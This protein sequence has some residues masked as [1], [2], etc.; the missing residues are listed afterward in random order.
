VKPRVFIASS[1]EGA[2]VAEGVRH[3]LKDYATCTSWFDPF[4][5]T[6]SASTIDNLLQKS[7]EHDF[8]I[9]IFSDDDIAKIRGTGVTVPRDNVVFESGLF[10]GMHGKDRCYIVM[11]KDVTDFH[12]LTDLLGY[13][14]AR[15]DSKLAKT[16]SGHYLGPAS[17]EII[18]A[19]EKSTWNR[20]QLEIKER[21]SLGAAT[22]KY[23]LKLYIQIRNPNHHPVIIESRSFSINPA[24][25][26]SRNAITTKNRFVPEFLIYRDSDSSKDVYRQ[27]CI[28]NFN[29]TIDTWIP[30][31]SSI[32]KKALDEAI[33]KKNVGIWKY[34]C[35]I[36][37]ESLTIC[38]YEQEF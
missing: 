27:S 12:L 4:V 13:T 25:K 21:S 22:L 3:N 1:K 32:T 30:I 9:F 7:D 8:A 20:F 37:G 2:N 16:D 14:T 26:F 23:P 19:I 10:M 35:Y 17:L 28:L 5:F 38:N 6:L 29:E 34:R 36:L 11:P 24:F 33:T 15:Y 31:D 18:D